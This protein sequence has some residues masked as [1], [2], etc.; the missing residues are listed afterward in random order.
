MQLKLEPPHSDTYMQLLQFCREA[1]IHPYFPSAL[2]SKLY[3]HNYLLENY[4]HLGKY[5]MVPETLRVPFPRKTLITLRKPLALVN[6]GAHILK[7][8]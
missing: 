7:I 2:L 8:I 4:V 1:L 3:V 5:L 6:H